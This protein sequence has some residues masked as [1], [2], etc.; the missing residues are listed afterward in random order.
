M[1]SGAPRDS[2]AFEVREAL[3]APGCAICQLAVRS[4]GKLIRSV[5]YEQVNDL[6]LRRE[7][8]RAHG[9]CN[10]HAFRWLREA[11]S[12]LGT[13]L[14]YRDVLNAA[15][16]ELDGA[17]PSGGQ[18]GRRWRGL[19]GGGQSQAVCPA[20]QAQTEAESRY[21]DALL[22][23]VA[24]DGG[25][26]E[27]SEGVCRRHALAAL[28]A[29]AEAGAIVARRT[30]EVV[31]RLIAHLDEVVRKEDYRFRHEPRTEAERAAPARAVAWAAGLHGLL[32]T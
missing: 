9:F 28:R 27:S 18:R 11:R 29:D 8:R 24:A 10:P 31:E 15:L 25:V 2:A 32:D 19:L 20:C 3:D 4:V 17:Q 12:V 14:I 21:L 30:R 26:L 6:G 7:L 1:S 16:R 22:A 23:L 5:A 13:A